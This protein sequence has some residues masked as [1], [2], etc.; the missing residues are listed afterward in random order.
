MPLLQFW[1]GWTISPV[2]SGISCLLT[3]WY[4]VGIRKILLESEI[5]AVC[6]YLASNS[7]CAELVE[8][9]VIGPLILTILNEGPAG[10]SKKLHEKYSEFLAGKLNIF[11]LSVNR[12]VVSMEWKKKQMSK[13]KP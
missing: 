8:K 3:F 12:K 11:L 7:I 4:N 10:A 2:Q 9:M 1:S 5:L 13:Q 6:L